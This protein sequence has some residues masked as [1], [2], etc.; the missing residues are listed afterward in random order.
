MLGSLTI[1]DRWRVRPPRAA[2]AAPLPGRSDGEIGRDRSRPDDVIL[3]A[4]G[5]NPLRRLRKALEKDG[6]LVIVGGEGGGRV[7]GGIGRQ[8]RAMLKSR[9]MG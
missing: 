7:T 9:Q 2:R 5:P 1:P 8:L 6:T 3:D 4:G